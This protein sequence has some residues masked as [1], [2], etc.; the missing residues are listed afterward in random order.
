MCRARVVS[1]R[2]CEGGHSQRL[3][4]RRAGERGGRRAQA[5][6][7]RAKDAQSARAVQLGHRER[8]Q[9]V[10]RHRPAHTHTVPTPH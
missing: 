2:Q 9:L 7:G 5:V 4:A 8:L 6:A 1:L 3:Q 10:V